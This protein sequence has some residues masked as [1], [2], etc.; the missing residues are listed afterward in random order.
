[1]LASQRRS[2]TG[3][4]H[5]AKIMRSGEPALQEKQE[6]Q[7]KIKYIIYTLI[8][9]GVAYLIYYR[10]AA[11]KKIAQDG[12][13]MGK[14]KGG[15]A[16]GLQVEGVVVTASDFTND[17]EVTGTLEANESVELRSEVSGLV[18]SIREAE[19]WY[20]VSRRCEC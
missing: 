3:I 19:D 7:M 8:V 17:L 13:G 10:I 15:S 14:G 20:E 9:L 5:Q 12:A 1:M 11:N 4:T 18:T 6:P 2:D 16:K